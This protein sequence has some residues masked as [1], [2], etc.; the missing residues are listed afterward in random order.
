MKPSR[1]EKIKAVEIAKTYIDAGFNH[2]LKM[3]SIFLT[4]FVI[5]E[6]LFLLVKLHPV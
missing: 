1:Q 5:L 3:N 4:G 2:V 6:I